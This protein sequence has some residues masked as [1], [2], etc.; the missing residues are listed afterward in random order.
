MTIR[1]ES[2]GGT[3]ANRMSWGD[4]VVFDCDDAAK[5]EFL[6]TRKAKGKVA[7]PAKSQSNLWFVKPDDIDRLGPPIGRGGVWADDK[8]KA[9]EWSDPYLLTGY[10]QRSLTL[11]HDADQTVTMELQVDLTGAGMWRTFKKFKVS[12]DAPSEYAF[13]SAFQAYWARLR[14]DR[15]CEAAAQFDFQ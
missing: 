14:A 3:P 4:S 13:P 6:N 9:G 5:N 2:V 15:D 1:G 7:G 12:N 8:V 10:D 11:S